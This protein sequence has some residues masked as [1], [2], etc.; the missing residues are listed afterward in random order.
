MKLIGAGLPRTATTTQMLALDKLGLPCYHMRNLLGD[1]PTQ[2]ELWE[3][4]TDG[5]GDWERL[6]DGFES[7]VDWPGAYFWRELIDV[8]PD[9]KV[10]LSVRDGEGFARSFMDTIVN[11]HF[12][13]SL[14]YHLSQARAQVDPLW[15]RWYQ[16][17]LRMTW[18][19]KSPWAGRQPE[20]EDLIEGMERWNDEVKSTVPAERLLVWEPTDGWE[21]LCEFLDVPVPEEPLPHINDTEM[22]RNGIAA[23]AM[24]ALGPWW[25]E[26][27]PKD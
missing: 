3:D 13:P 18:G 11:L 24:A 4:A 9:A 6:F 7:E 17:M 23:G 5:R 8:Y 21:P 12:G 27:R 2:L 25:E 14:M 1:L 16:L 15:K 19:G 10:L 20:R 26:H 22:F